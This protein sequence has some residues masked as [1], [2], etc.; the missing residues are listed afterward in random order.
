MNKKEA[1]GGEKE[2]DKEK[3]T[4]KREKNKREISRMIEEKR[5]AKKKRRGEVS[6]HWSLEPEPLLGAPAAVPGLPSPELP[7]AAVGDDLPGELRTARGRLPVEVA[8]VAV[9][10]RAE[11]VAEGPGR[12]SHVEGEAH[13]MCRSV[14]NLSH[15][16]VYASGSSR[17]LGPGLRLLEFD[18]CPEL[19]FGIIRGE[20]FGQRR[21]LLN[22]LQDTRG[23]M[24]FGG[25]KEDVG[26]E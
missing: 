22:H 6:N 14:G 12:S 4:K 15:L 26:S 1:N 3:D 25:A 5:R 17:P 16:L 24:K 7:D 23:V 18:G 13:G 10:P 11:G 9:W 19:S 8:R 20:F 21:D 2:K